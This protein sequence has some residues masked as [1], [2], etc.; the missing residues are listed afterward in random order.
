MLDSGTNLVCNM[1]LHIEGSQ[2]IHMLVKIAKYILFLFLFS[3][4][5]TNNN[6]NICNS[7]C[8]L[9]EFT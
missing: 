2:K 9:E 6:E 5:T 7:A 4:T 8:D 3:C 1:G